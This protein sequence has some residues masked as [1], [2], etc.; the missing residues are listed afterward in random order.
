MTRPVCR[1]AFVCATLAL[2]IVTPAHAQPPVDEQEE[3]PPPPVGDDPIE[4]R[5]RALEARDH[6]RDEEL[7]RALERV[8]EL[9]RADAE[10]A[11]APTEAIDEEEEAEEPAF[12]PLANMVTRFE[13]REGYTALGV[14]GTG[15]VPGDNDCIRY[16]ARVGFTTTPLTIAD[17]VKASVRFLPQLAGFWAL[18]SLTGASSSGGVFDPT[19]GLHEAALT[20][21]LGPA[22]RLEVGRFEMIYGEHLVIGNLDWHPNARAFDG[23]R[24]HIQPDAGGIWVDVFFTM[25]NEGGLADFGRGDRYFYGAYADFGPAIAE[26]LHLDAYA[27]GLQANDSTDALGNSVA[28]SLRLTIGAR[29]RYRIDLVDFRAETG[30]QVGREGV[31]LPGDAPTILA[32]QF[33]GEVGLNF[34]EDRLRV[35]LEGAFASGD[36][37]TTADTAEGWNQLFPTAHAFL[38]FTDVMG[39]RTNVFDGVAHLTGKPIDQLQI[40]LDVHVFLRPERG[41]ASSNYAGNEWN[42]NLI[43]R[44]GAGLRLRGMYGIFVPNEGVY[45]SGDPAHYLEVEL[46]YVLD[47]SGRGRSLSQ[48]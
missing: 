23:T 17:D 34:L 33:D 8:A 35:A 27:L 4:A 28:W 18:P 43:W 44:P 47:W 7:Q 42:L 9:E 32:G 19:L 39:G 41:A 46:G 13:H 2:A 30:I 10:A 48:A 45:P 11:T 6:E 16:R 37:P 25:L 24:L 3:V 14:P 40:N 22:A 38:G 36:D 12:R 29:F 20:L 15:C 1:T 21:Q 26:N 31:A 5:L